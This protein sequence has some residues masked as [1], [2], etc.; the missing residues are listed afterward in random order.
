MIDITFMPYGPDY[1]A[2]GASPA[3]LIPSIVEEVVRYDQQGF[4]RMW[5][6]EVNGDAMLPLMLAAAHTERLELGTGIVTAFPRSPM[7]LAASAHDL[8]LYSQGRFS[9]GLGSQVR[10]HVERRL[11]G[12]WDRPVPR[13]R[14]LILALR[15][16]WSCW[17]EGTPLAF[18]GE[19]FRH[20]LMTPAFMP[21]S[22]PYGPPPVFVAAVGPAMTR[23]A[24][25]VADGMLAHGVMSRSYLQEVTIPIVEQGL[26]AAGRQRAEFQISAPALIASGADDRQL[27]ASVDSARS[28]LAFYLATP[29]YRRVLD[30]HGW[31]DLQT[32]LNALARS[33]DWNALR[34]HLPDEVL[35][36]FVMAGPAKVVAEK[37]RERLEILDRITLSF[38][39]GSPPELAG[40]VFEA[41]GAGA[42]Q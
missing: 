39:P 30:H 14:E 13:M 22:S 38:V 6:G 9:L 35:E 1:A 36:T 42:P 18:E 27:E 33:G 11:G 4:A 26:A 31:G 3:R 17:N 24:A 21:P 7:H 20:T 15:A 28:L 10:A 19:F 2:R 37:V 25:E 23:M 8:Q 29:A 12:V 40:E 41:V 32:D 34:R 16:I 5:A